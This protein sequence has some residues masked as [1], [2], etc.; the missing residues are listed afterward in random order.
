MASLENGELQHRQLRKAPKSPLRA[1]FLHELRP[2]VL[3]HF[4]QHRHVRYQALVDP[5]IP[6][7]VVIPF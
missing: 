5:V 2:V 1:E 4:V 7:L 6:V 3:V